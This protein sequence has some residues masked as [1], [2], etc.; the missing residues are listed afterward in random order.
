MR[1]TIKINEEKIPKREGKC[2]VPNEF[3]QMLR[4][5][6]DREISSGSRLMEYENTLYIE[7]AQCFIYRLYMYIEKLE[8][9]EA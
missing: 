5:R 6:F 2:V 4:A 3:E 7:W 9:G 1:P 8:S